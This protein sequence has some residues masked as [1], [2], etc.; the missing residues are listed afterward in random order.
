MSGAGTRGKAK[1][2]REGR[3]AVRGTVKPASVGRQA[4]ALGEEKHGSVRRQ[5]SIIITIMERAPQEDFEC[6]IVCFRISCCRDAIAVA[7]VP[8][9]SPVLRVMLH[10]GSLSTISA[11]LSAVECE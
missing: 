1:Y 5:V 7:F 10:S 9:F 8:Q 3:Q 2:T 11:L 4:H 6:A